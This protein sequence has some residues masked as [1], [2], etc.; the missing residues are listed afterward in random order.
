MTRSRNDFDGDVGQSADGEQAIYRFSID[1]IAVACVFA[2]AF[3]F[4][5]GILNNALVY[6][7]VALY[8][9]EAREIATVFGGLTYLGALFIARLRPD[10]L[11][12][13]RI[14]VTALLFIVLS[15]FLL[16]FG[17]TTQDTPTTVVA[18]CLRAVAR[19]WAM[20]LIVAS[21]V[22]VK[23]LKSVP[24]VVAAGL[25]LANLCRSL[26]S[27][28]DSPFAAPVGL[29]ASGAVPILILT[30][31]A[32]PVLERVRTGAPADLTELLHPGA[33]LK[34]SHGLF[35]CVLLFSTASGYTMTLGEI[36]NA[37]V[38]TSPL[39]FAILLIVVYAIVVKCDHQQDRLFSFS[40]ILTMA[41]FL[42][43]PITYNTESIA[44]NT[45]ITIGENCFDILLWTMLAGVGRRNLF[46]MLPTFGLAE[47]CSAVGTDIGAIVG[48]M[49][50]AFMQGEPRTTVS[51]ALALSFVFFVFLWVGFR[52]FSF[53]EV[54]YSVEKS[55]NNKELGN[56]I[57][58][59]TCTKL[60]A[61]KDI[62]N[63]LVSTSGSPATI[64]TV[65]NNYLDIDAEK[66]GRLNSDNSPISKSVQTNPE[67][68]PKDLSATFQCRCDSLSSQ[69]GL[70]EREGE[71]FAMLARGRNARFIMEEFVLS[72][73][74]VKSHIKHIY[75][76]LGVH[77]Q[78]ELI[79]RVEKQN[80]ER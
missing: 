1:G 80:L 63:Q 56:G 31:I 69:F 39:A 20:T 9:G 4:F 2:F 28:F 23:H 35:L 47:F 68:E 74:T 18:L 70:T 66:S 32:L 5:S 67:E 60:N 48:H 59:S 34:P 25:F 21:L 15:T 16:V 8:F 22:R 79:D 65:Q 17:L 54:L 29:G 49:S 58:Q 46:A 33:F 37:P 41:G 27:A 43:V 62:L 42:M 19:A 10:W 26:I 11:F 7:R 77:S 12:V 76:K 30:G 45:L 72:R 53:S 6:S 44:A 73:N 13:R 78:Q 55:S 57:R 50:N 51:L 38:E 61:D 40:V 24:L 36:G 3:L 64:F 71:I 52:R 14:S 75:A